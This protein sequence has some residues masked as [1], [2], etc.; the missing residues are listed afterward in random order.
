[1]VRHPLIT[2]KTALANV[3]LGPLPLTLT[4]DMDNTC[5]HNMLMS[6]F[7]LLASA[8]GYELLM[9]LR[10]NPGQ[11]FHKMD[12]PHS[13]ERLK[14]LANQ[15]T[16]YIRPLQVDLLELAYTNNTQTDTNHQV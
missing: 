3:G 7:P 11:G 2:T 4:L 9:Y 6:S 12:T 13:T 15:S 8:G 14:A 5:V 16:I 10:Q 1:M